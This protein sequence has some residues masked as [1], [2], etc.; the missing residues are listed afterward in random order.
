MRSYQLKAVAGAACLA[1]SAAWAQTSTP[2]TSNDPTA[3]APTAG[4]VVSGSRI[5]RDN[6][7]SA[8]PLQVLTIDAATAAGLGTTTSVLQSNT[9][10]GGAAQINNAFG[11]FVTD[12]G[13]GANTVGLRGFNPTRSLL[14]LNGR[15]LSPSG[16]RGSVGAADL[17]T[18]PTTMVDRIEVLKDGSSSIYGSDAVA[19]VINVITKRNVSGIVV[20]GRIT[21]PTEGSGNER[22]MSVLT[23]FNKGPFFISGAYEV[24]DRQALTLADRDWTQ[25]NTD[26]RR[27]VVNGVGGEWG[28]ADFIDP[29]T[30]QPKCYPITGTGSNGVT[31]NTLGVT[32]APGVRVPGVGAPG[33]VGTTFDRWRPNPAIT[34]GLVGYEGVGGGTNNLNVRD[35]FDP[36]MLNASLISPTTNQNLFINGGLEL[37]A[38]GDAELYFEHLYSRRDSSQTGYRQLVI[39]YPVGSPLIPADL[40]RFVFLPAGGSQITNGL[41][42]G[43]RAFIGFG[44]TRSTQLVDFNRTVVGLRGS[45]GKKTG[46]DYDVSASRSTNRGEYT[47]NS[48][49]TNRLAQS[50]NVTRSGSGFS[51][52]NTA[53]GCVA[54][55]ALTAGVIGG[56]L[57]ADW[58]NFVFGDAVGTSRYWE[59]VLTATATG[60]LFRLP[61]GMVKAAVGAEYRHNRIDDTPSP[62]SVNENLY[63]LTGARPTRGSDRV[64]DLFAEVEIPVLSKKPFAQDVTINLSTRYSNYRSYG[65]DS[66]YKAGG[67]WTPVRGFSLRGTT[68]TSYRAPALFEQFLGP[69]TGFLSSTTDP[70]N[71]WDAAGN[72]GTNRFNNCKSE[73]L[74]SGYTSTQSLTVVAAGGAEAGL[75]A[76]T[77]RNA[78]VGFVLQPTIGATAKVSLAVDYFKILVEDGVSQVGAGNILSRCYDSVDFRAG[79][80]FCR[81]ISARAT[82]T[83]A[84]RVNNSYVNIS[85]DLVRG[86][87]YNLRYEDR[88]GPGTLLTTLGVTRFMNRESRVFPE[89]PVRNIVGTLNAPSMT[90]SLGVNY[91]VRTWRMFYGM[92]YTRGQESYTINRLNPDTSAFKLDVPAYILHTVSVGYRAPKWGATVGIRNLLNAVPPQISSGLI[93]RVGNAP[94]YSGYDYIGRMLFLNANR[95]F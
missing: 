24:Y 89:D 76:E 8:A 32:S 33:S 1:C 62:D 43:A 57:P 54:A 72:V 67:I 30:G 9:V 83:N 95:Q 37:S 42:T 35:T 79:G 61:A 6:F 28:S 64:R 25:C 26:Y 39:D 49:F 40:S 50:L 63:N 94:I 65:A 86:Y 44:N 38:L 21:A 55:P 31:I 11:G 47:F 77:S 13:P 87:D 52:V 75:R 68:G 90:G 5:K 41:A 48:F 93:S 80:G 16:T 29:K 27:T 71:N 70:C 53:N 59:D 15:R 85:S 10:T 66:T 81:L 19:G 73:G 69:T 46:W 17:N 3:E 12:G 45:L 58:V 4:V 60:P 20:D 34:T 88:V 78:T 84:L 51:C 23:G 82:G 7:N 36:R 92:D 14:L 56:Q 18:L 74:P 91:Q 2:P 22:R